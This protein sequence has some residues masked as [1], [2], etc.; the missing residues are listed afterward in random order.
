MNI[1]DKFCKDCLQNVTSMKCLKFSKM[2]MKMIWSPMRNYNPVTDWQNFF[3]V[4]FLEENPR[5]WWQKNILCKAYGSY[6]TNKQ[7]TTLCY[8]ATI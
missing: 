8:C 5:N 1:L 6:E 2:F 7:K 3:Q 4:F